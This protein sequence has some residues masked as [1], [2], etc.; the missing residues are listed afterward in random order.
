MKLFSCIWIIFKLSCDLS[1]DRA[2]IV[3]LVRGYWGEGGGG[4]C[5]RLN[6]VFIGEIE[7]PSFNWL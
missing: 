7:G 1:V 5:S 2:F 4:L 6:I 3:V